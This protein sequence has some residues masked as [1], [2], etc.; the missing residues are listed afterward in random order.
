[1]RGRA[2]EEFSRLRTSPY[3]RAGTVSDENLYTAFEDTTI[4]PKTGVEER[5]RRWAIE[6]IQNTY[7]WGFDPWTTW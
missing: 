2:P 6:V 7:S 5:T 1:V 4:I 3:Y